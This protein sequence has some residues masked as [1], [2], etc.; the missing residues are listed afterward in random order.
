MSLHCRTGLQLV[1]RWIQ[2]HE[3]LL[4]RPYEE[5]VRLWNGGIDHL[6]G[7]LKYDRPQAIMKL[8]NDAQHHH[9]GV[10][11]RLKQLSAFCRKVAACPKAPP[12]LSSEVVQIDLTEQTSLQDLYATEVEEMLRSL[13]DTSVVSLSF[14]ISLM[15]WFLD[16]CDEDSA[17]SATYCVPFVS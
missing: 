15:H 13:A 12:E 9:S 1:P 17:D 5:R 3:A 8:W 2:S 11:H 10:A 14:L 6:L 4:E 7:Q 16:D